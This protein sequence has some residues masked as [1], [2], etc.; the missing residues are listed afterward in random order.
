[1][2]SKTTK[3]NP[4]ENQWSCLDNHLAFALTFVPMTFSLDNDFKIRVARLFSSK[5]KN[6]IWINFGGP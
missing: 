4:A 2:Q 3:W 1:M 6:P 5:P